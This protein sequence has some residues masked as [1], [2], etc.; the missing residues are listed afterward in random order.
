MKLYLTIIQQLRLKLNIL[1][2]EITIKKIIR[3]L[4]NRFKHFQWKYF[5]SFFLL[6]PIKIGGVKLYLNPNDNVVSFRCFWWRSWESLQVS[7]MKER[8]LKGSV[9]IDIGA[10]I[11]IYT[12]IMSKEVGENGQVIAFEPE[13]ENLFF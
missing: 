12:L 9:C 3:Y 1:K 7:K 8:I 6:F 2:K 4:L 11:G 5:K 10:N 13:K